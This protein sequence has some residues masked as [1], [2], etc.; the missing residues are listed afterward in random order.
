MPTPTTLPRNVRPNVNSSSRPSST[1]LPVPAPPSKSTFATAPNGEEPDTLHIGLAPASSPSVRPPTSDAPLPEPMPAPA[2]SDSVGNDLNLPELPPPPSN[3]VDRQQEEQLLDPPSN[4]IPIHEDLI[5]NEANLPDKELEDHGNPT[6]VPPAEGYFAT[7][8]YPNR[9]LP[10]KMPTG[11]ITKEAYRFRY[12]GLTSDDILS[13]IQV[14]QQRSEAC[15]AVF[16][17]VLKSSA[18]GNFDVQVHWWLTP[19]LQKYHLIGDDRQARSRYLRGSVLPD[20]FTAFP[21]LHPDYIQ[22]RDSDMEK[23]YLDK[24]CNTISA[25]YHQLRLKLKVPGKL[26][27][28]DKDVIKWLSEPSQ[29]PRPHDIW[30]RSQLDRPRASDSEGA[31]SEPSQ[32]AKDWQEKKATC[33]EELGAEAWEANRLSIEQ[34]FRKNAFEKL[35]D[36][37]RKV[38]TRQAMAK[39]KPVDKTTAFVRGL[40]FITHV[41]KRFTDLAQV[42]MT[43]LLGAPDPQEP[44]KLLIYHDTYVG[45]APAHIEDFWSGPSQL[46]TRQILPE[47]RRFVADVFQ[48]SQDTVQVEPQALPEFAV[49][50]P[51]PGLAAEKVVH[52]NGIRF[53]VTSPLQNWCVRSA[54]C[55]EIVK[56]LQ[57]SLGDSWKET[58]GRARVDFNAMRNRTSDFTSSEYLPRSCKKM[59]AEPGGVMTLVDALE[60]TICVPSDPKTMDPP[61]LEAWYKMF[62]DDSIPE[63]RRFRWVDSKVAV[64]ARTKKIPSSMQIEAPK[65]SSRPSSKGKGKASTSARSNR[66]PDHKAMASEENSPSDYAEQSETSAGEGPPNPRERQP[67]VSRSGHVS[68]APPILAPISTRRP[69]SAGQ[70]PTT[71]T[72]SSNTDT[73]VRPTDSHVVLPDPVGTRRPAQAELPSWH[74]MATSGTVLTTPRKTT[75]GPAAIPNSNT[76]FKLYAAEDRYPLYLPAQAIEQINSFEYFHN[77]PLPSGINNNAGVDLPPLADLITCCIDL[78]LLFPMD[79][80]EKEDGPY[81]IQTPIDALWANL[82][83]HKKPLPTYLFASGL[84]R[85]SNQLIVP[86]VVLPAVGHVQEQ[87]NALEGINMCS[88]APGAPPQFQSWT[89]Y[90]VVTA[91]FLSFLYSIPPSETPCQLSQELARFST[92]L[93]EITCIYL[94]YRYTT[95]TMSAFIASHPKATVKPTIASSTST[96]GTRWLEAI[97]PLFNP[98]NGRSL[99]DVLS[100]NWAQQADDM[101]P[102][103][104]LPFFHLHD[105]SKRWLVINPTLTLEHAIVDFAVA[106]NLETEEFGQLATYQQY[107]LLA[108]IFA[109]TASPHREASDSDWI[110]VV[111]TILDKLEFM[112]RGGELYE[113]EHQ[114]IPP[115][116]T[117][118]EVAP[119][120]P[121]SDLVPSRHPSV[122]SPPPSPRQKSSQT[123]SDS[124]LMPTDPLPSISADCQ[125][126]NT[127]N[128]VALQEE[129][130]TIPQYPRPK[131]RIG[132]RLRWIPGDVIRLTARGV[133]KEVKI[134]QKGADPNNLVL[135]WITS[136]EPVLSKNGSPI[137]LPPFDKNILVHPSPF[138]PALDRD[139]FIRDQQLPPFL[140]FHEI[141]S[142][143]HDDYL[144]DLFEKNPESRPPSPEPEGDEIDNLLDE[145][146]VQALQLHI[147]RR[148]QFRES[149]GLPPDPQ[150]L[151]DEEK[152]ALLLKSTTHA[153]PDPHTAMQLPPPPSERLPSAE[154]WPSSSGSAEP[155]GIKQP[156]GPHAPGHERGEGTESSGQPMSTN[157]RLAV[158]PTNTD[159]H[160]VEVNPGKANIKPKCGRPRSAVAS[161]PSTGPQMPDGANQ[162]PASLSVP[163]ATTPRRTTRPRKPVIEP[164]VPPTRKAPAKLKVPA[165]ASGSGSK[166]KDA[167]QPELE[168]AAQG[169]KRKIPAAAGNGRLKAL[170]ESAAPPRQDSGSAIRTR[171]K[172]K[173]AQAA[174]EPEDGIEEPPAKK[175]RLK[176]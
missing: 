171:S 22:V 168:E 85:K 1:T 12:N 54:E 176:G 160:P 173:A 11:A 89:H 79:E 26:E 102:E 63:A 84:C 100:Q 119:S 39:N 137:P 108:A 134:R 48:K 8:H 81:D 88:M 95:C 121:G 21:D 144:L 105:V 49:P 153:P 163:A 107:S 129:I 60:E 77:L 40:P 69:R 170:V 67:T 154:P 93:T 158:V 62:V 61:V 136:Q 122:G 82:E 2:P 57:I 53:I 83:D 117:M 139:C 175:V 98:L 56:N 41:L 74:G 135:T 166:P 20:L 148:R 51:T 164:Q 123:S 156:D 146:K 91:Q 9:K 64:P 162:L 3:Q 52:V 45:P 18:K 112:S 172:S 99:V 50:P 90:L 150:D 130:P 31:Q 43:I 35:P 169:R 143:M 19:V 27:V 161:R 140:P 36:A 106:V 13:K 66:K 116:P 44:G 72:P 152:L 78:D 73:D 75:L 76:F 23:A 133:S 138:M 125:E 131:S 80:A 86:A 128:T 94:I 124:S 28:V 142:G 147:E 5:F 159:P 118:L 30:A 55:D 6:M 127:E 165:T 15:P 115:P 65:T 110:H 114:P 17:H 151:A 167:H 7:M 155:S 96:L 58:F 113:N 70:A 111:E 29:P 120:G 132:G 38:W 157:N 32:F 59:Q 33:L 42:P 92:R 145:A 34:D 25:A 4:P 101:Q 68:A 24:T 174:V 10:L 149:L 16:Q 87:L 37:E 141:L 47:W 46:G 109:L 103:D 14:I 71:A 97:H 104:S 126:A